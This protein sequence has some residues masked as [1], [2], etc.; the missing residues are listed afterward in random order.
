VA[1]VDAKKP[2]AVLLTVNEREFKKRFVVQFLATYAAKYYEDAASGT[3]TWES[4]QPVEDAEELA[5]MA[6]QE[7]CRY[8]GYP[9]IN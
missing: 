8:G 1:G 7:Y 5:E 3:R 2:A 9:E 6:W 4:L